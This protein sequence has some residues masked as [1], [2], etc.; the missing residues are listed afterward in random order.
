MPQSKALQRES[1]PGLGIF[2][3]RRLTQYVDTW[4]VAASAIACLV[5]VPLLVIASSLL[6]PTQGIWGH[7]IDNVL[8]GLLSNTAWL[9]LGVSLGTFFIGV[10][11]GWLTAVCD[12]PGRRLFSWTLL[13]PLAMPAYV[14]AFIYLGIFDFT[15]PVQSTFRTLFPQSG[16]HFPDIRSTGGVIFVMTLALYPYVYLLCR[17]A[18]LT[19]SKSSIEAARTLGLTHF[20][21]FLKVSLPMARPWIAGGLMLV[22]MET[23]ADFGAVSILN[24]D[25][26]TTA[27]YKAWFGFFSLTGAAQLSSILVFIVFLVIVL[28]QR[29]RARMSYSHSSGSGQKMDRIELSKGFGWTALSFCLMVLL[30]GF[31]VPCVQL[32]AW[33]LE[34]FHVEFDGRYVW[35]VGRT[36]F[37]AFVAALLTLSG[38]IVLAY[39]KRH[40]PDSYTL[41]LTRVATLGYSLPGTVLAVGIFIPVAKADNLLIRFMQSAFDFEISSLLQG[42]L[43]VMFI[44]Y[45][46]RFMTT[47]FNAV[48]SSMQRITTSIDEASRLMGVKGLALL[49]RIHIPLLKNGLLTA[50]ILIF[51]EVMKEMPITLMTRPFG[52]D[53]L[54]VKIFE[55][56]SEG[57]WE[58][59]ALPA[60]A[61]VLVGL[62]PVIFLTHHSEKQHRK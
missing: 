28:E 26:F 3:A 8:A 32:V 50:L 42:T 29:F 6:K 38:A 43:I 20:E 23:L 40:R 13:L 11:T 44:A 48:D 45:L 57:E 24:F 60:V 1:V 33:T 27:I 59:S 2:S 62:V 14:L 39:A 31:I 9:V 19:Q 47:G 46:I 37:L 21:A 36:L 34:S 4:R 10:S 52:W 58:R 30:A 61:L 22:I 15:G 7:L 17:N 16:F 12:F 51:V 49:R 53:T 25:T 41:S 35:L 56:T 5:A 54:A 55:L 18:F